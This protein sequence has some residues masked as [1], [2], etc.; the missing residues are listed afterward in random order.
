MAT[1]GWSIFFGQS[2]GTLARAPGDWLRMTE[3]V[4]GTTKNPAL[5]D[6][7]EQYL[8]EFHNQ[9]V[10]TNVGPDAGRLRIPD[11]PVTIRALLTHTAGIQDTRPAAIHEYPQLMNVPLDQVANQLALQQALGTVLETAAAL[12]GICGSLCTGSWPPAGW[13]RGSRF[14]RRGYQ[15]LNPALREHPAPSWFDSE[16]FW[17]IPA[18]ARRSG[19]ISSSPFSY[20]YWASVNGTMTAVL[21]STGSPIRRHGAYRHC[22]TASAADG[23]SAGLPDTRFISPTSPLW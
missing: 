8:P 17:R 10:A 2:I 22:I 6:P 23:T 1:D 3:L 13:G 18:P 16:A 5:R 21:T 20:R 19:P 12:H 4:A 9:R 11:Y 14:R 7:V 15:R